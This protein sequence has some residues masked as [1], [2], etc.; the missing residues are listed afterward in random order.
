VGDGGAESPGTG[1][2]VGYVEQ[3]LG[4]AGEVEEFE[5]ARP[6]GIADTCFNGGVGDIVT[7]LVTDFT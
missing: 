2:V 1:G 6:L 3:E 4:T 7:F 5:A